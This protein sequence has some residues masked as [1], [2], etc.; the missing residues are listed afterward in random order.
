VQTVGG[1]AVVFL[2]TSDPN[3]Y[4]MRPVRLGAEAGGRYPVLEGL[5]V[6]DRVVT[7]GSFMLR[8]EWLKLHPE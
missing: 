8:A 7:G 3:T 1:R 4:V 5:F 2:A 6:G